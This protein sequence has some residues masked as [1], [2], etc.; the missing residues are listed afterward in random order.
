MAK[1]ESIPP[2]IKKEVRARCGYGC[3][4]CGGA[5]Y[6]YHHIEEHCKV[7]CHKAENIT[8][9]CPNHHAKVTRKFIDQDELSY[10]YKYPFTIE[11]GYADDTFYKISSDIPAIIGSNQ[12]TGNSQSGELIID[13]KG[14]K[15]MWLITPE[16]SDAPSRFSSIFYDK[17][18]RIF[19]AIIDNEFRALTNSNNFSD[20]ET[21]AGKYKFKFKNTESNLD[22]SRKNSSLVFNGTLYC[23]GNTL[24]MKDDGM[25]VIRPDGTYNTLS[26]NSFSCLKL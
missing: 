18:G 5:I 8:L 22:I 16:N 13:S 1:R 25:E 24:N 2:E 9:L 3:V 21:T 26:K 23:R 15:L 12:I 11:R 17:N 19:A 10:R 20:L 7:Q 14:E 6:E 4:V